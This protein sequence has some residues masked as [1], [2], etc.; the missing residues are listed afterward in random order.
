MFHEVKIPLADAEENIDPDILDKYIEAK[1]VLDDKANEG[2]NLATAKSRLTNINDRPIGTA[3]NNPLLD[4]RE[5]EI[6]LED[7]TT[8]RIFANKNTIHRA[9][10]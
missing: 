3:H 4:D 7:G 6:E 5:Y 2:G 9:W 8:D 10:Q 1:I